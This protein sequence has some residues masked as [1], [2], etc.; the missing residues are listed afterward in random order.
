MTGKKN[1]LSVS[2][3]SP[4]TKAQR[5]AL[6]AELAEHEAAAGRLEMQGNKKT[7]HHEAA[8]RIRAELEQNEVNDELD[9]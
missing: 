2:T 7:Y 8:A 3:S 9:K 4:L 1:D 6:E 5:E